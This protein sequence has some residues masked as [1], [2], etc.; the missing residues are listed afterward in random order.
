MTTTG[1][2]RAV[3]ASRGMRE[4]REG[5]GPHAAEQHDVL[6]RDGHDVQ[7]AAAPE[8]VDRLL[9]DAFVVAQHHALQHLAD[10]RMHARAKV[11][12]RGEPQTVDQALQAAAPAADAQRPR[13]RRLSDD[14]LAAASQVAAVVELAP[15][16]PRAA[17][18]DRRRASR[19]SAAP[20]TSGP[21]ESSANRWPSSRPRRRWAGSRTGRPSTDMAVTASV[22]WSSSIG[23]QV[24]EHRLQSETLS[25]DRAARSADPAARASRSAPTSQADRRGTGWPARRAAR[26]RARRCRDV[27]PGAAGRRQPWR[28]PARRRRPATSPAIPASDAARPPQYAASSRCGGASRRNTGHTVMKSFMAANLAS[29]MPGTFLIS[30]IGLEAAVGRA[31]VD[32]LLRR[33]RADALQGVELG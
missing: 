30:S 19:R 2:S 33:G 1:S 3:R 12:A 31:V 23:R 21:H 9:V 27:V 15:A 13:S 24:G 6:A 29:P 28:W 20:S 7:Q 11:R 26:R 17:T 25:P 14:V 4:Q 8:V 32:D 5:E 18:L 22:T 16:R 10:G